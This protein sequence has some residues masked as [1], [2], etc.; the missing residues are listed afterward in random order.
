MTLKKKS[1]T[2][3]KR[4]QAFKVTP[5]AKRQFA[6]QQFLAYRANHLHRENTFFEFGATE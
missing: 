4:L 1:H 3:R 6:K 5:K 2:Q